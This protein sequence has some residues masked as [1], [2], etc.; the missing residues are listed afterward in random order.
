MATITSAQS[1][2]FN[3]TSTW[4][5]GVVPVDADAFVIAQTH[6]VTV[7]DDRRVTNGYD[8]S[9]VEGCL[10]I[11]SN[12]QLRM[13]GNLTINPASGATQHFAEGTAGSGAK[14]EMTNGAILEIRGTNSDAHYIRMEQEDYSWIECDGTNPNSKTTLSSSTS[15]GAMYVPVTSATGFAEGDWVSMFVELEDIDDYEV[16]GAVRTEGAIIHDISSNNIYVRQFVSPTTT[17]SAVRG[18]VITVADAAVFREGY[19]IIFGT[20]SNLNARTITRINFKQNRLILDSNVTGSVVGETVYQS[21]L[22]KSHAS[23]DSFQKVATSLTANASSGQANITVASTAGM[24]VGDKLWIEANNDFAIDNGWD[25]ESL[26]TISS[27]SSNTITLTGN[28]DND[29]LSGAWVAIWSRDT[30]IRSTSPGDSSQRPFI[31]TQRDADT[32]G[33]YRR[34]RFRNILFDGIGSNSSNSTWY[35]GIMIGRCSYE[36]NSYGQY[37]S[38]FEGNCW[39]PNNRGNNSCVFHR[40]WHQGILRNNILYNGTLNYWRYSSNNHITFTNNISSR[41]NYVVAVHDGFY[42]Q[43]NDTSYNHYSRSDDYGVQIYH[44]ETQSGKFRHNYIVNHEQRPMYFGYNMVNVWDK[45]W[46]EGFRYMPYH[47]RGQDTYFLNSYINPVYRNYDINT[48][49]YWDTPRNSMKSTKITFMNHNFR[50]NDVYEISGYVTRKWDHDENEWFVKRD[51]WNDNDAGWV[52]HVYVPAGA[53]VHV[54]CEIKLNNFSGSGSTYPRLEAYQT[55][56]YL[57]GGYENNTTSSNWGTSSNSYVKDTPVRGFFHSANYTAA[58]ASGYER[59]SVTI[60]AQNHDYFLAYCVASLNNEDG[61]GTDEGWWQKRYEIYMDDKPFLT[62]I[63]HGFGF[64][65]LVGRGTS[66]VR[67]RKT[68]IGGR[69]R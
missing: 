53:T 23:G 50:R 57:F 48:N 25:Y 18:N 39:T 29:R 45:L 21:G 11:V 38:G 24:N 62:N 54:A 44:A 63:N 35:R 66:A 37:A 34:I 6:L 43:Y 41:G 31:Y 19:K 10:K 51:G 5:G 36:N 42:G 17:I 8:N 67:T 22:E 20:G 32:G 46:I 12:G 13:N 59:K 49:F 27:I 2:N 7:N 52:E 69:L 3:S 26:Y 47:F 14:F 40:D 61:D 60:E 30:Q 68:R 64:N 33:Y 15:E 28:L 9:T 1:G 4:S 65:T 55:L 16:Q 56:D 58:A